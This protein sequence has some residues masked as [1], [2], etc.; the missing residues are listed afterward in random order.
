VRLA[1][2]ALRAGW[3][4]PIGL[5]ALPRDDFVVAVAVID[6]ALEQEAEQA[7]KMKRKGR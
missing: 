5:L 3:G 4:D 1:A 7:R 6:A 2:R